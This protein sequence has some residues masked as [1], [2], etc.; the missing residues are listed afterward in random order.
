M[1]L[2]TEAIFLLFR[3]S[4]TAIDLSCN[5]GDGDV[6]LLWSLKIRIIKA[7]HKSQE[8]FTSHKVHGEAKLKAQGTLPRVLLR[9]ALLLRFRR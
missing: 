8:L 7:F 3:N 2:G 9:S 4:A 6:L 1:E 5:G